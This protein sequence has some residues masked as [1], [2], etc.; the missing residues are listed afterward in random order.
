MAAFRIGGVDIGD[1]TPTHPADV[2]V[3]RTA[4]RS[5][6]LRVVLREGRN[7]QIRRTA[8]ALGSRVEWLV[9]IRFG[10]IELG[11]LA[12]GDAREATDEERRALGLSP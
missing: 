5:A 11:D 4:P 9:R 7:R 6:V 12:P 10:P 1:P 8:E 3:E 2:R